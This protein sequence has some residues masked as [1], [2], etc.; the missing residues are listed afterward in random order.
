MQDGSIWETGF[1]LQGELGNG[2][3]TNSENFVQGLIAT[4]APLEDVLMIGKN[5]GN[6]SGSETLGYGLNTTAITKEGDVYT[7]RRQHLW[8]DRR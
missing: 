7:C 6:I 8:S 1:N 4:G 5:N 3:N 2:T